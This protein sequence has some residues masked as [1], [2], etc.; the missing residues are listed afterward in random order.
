MTR[1]LC[2][3]ISSEVCKNSSNMVPVSRQK[4]ESIGFY[5]IKRAG[6]LGEMFPS[7]VWPT[8]GVA[9]KHG[10]VRQVAHVEARLGTSS[11][12]KPNIWS[13]F[14]L[15][16]TGEDMVT[17]ARGRPAY[18]GSVKMMVTGG[19]TGVYRQNYLFL[20][21]QDHHL[22]LDKVGHFAWMGGQ[23][24]FGDATFYLLVIRSCTCNHPLS[25]MILKTEDHFAPYSTL[26]PA[27]EW[28]SGFITNQETGKLNFSLTFYVLSTQPSIATPRHQFSWNTVIDQF[29]LKEWLRSFC[30]SLI[31]RITFNANLLPLRN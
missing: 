8:A 22:N 30:A 25:Q 27:L 18:W 14:H 13:L 6:C 1:V 9:I 23:E 4:V 3:K 17:L 31:L 11:C 16:D 21:T 7:N 12:A 15:V 2:V 19:E 24:Y 26:T 5:C 10:G 29:K 28:Q 20:V